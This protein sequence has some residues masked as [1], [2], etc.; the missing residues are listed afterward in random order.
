MLCREARFKIPGC[1]IAFA[2]LGV[3]HSGTGRRISAGGPAD[4]ARA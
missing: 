3:S 4:Y 2:D 1:A